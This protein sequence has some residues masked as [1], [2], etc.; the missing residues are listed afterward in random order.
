MTASSASFSSNTAEVSAR[1]EHLRQFRYWTEECIPLPGT[2]VRIGLEPV[3]GLIPVWGDLAGAFL[4]CYVPYEAY[5][6]GA[7]P[8]LIAKMLAVILLDAVAG[9]IP[10]AGDILD[11]VLQSNSIN[12][13]ML[14]DALRS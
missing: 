3:I 8:S 14:E 12:V 9:T 13:E 2:N 6:M 10:I 1:L 5:R 4:S 7:P 11:A